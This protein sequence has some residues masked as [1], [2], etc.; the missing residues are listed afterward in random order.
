MDPVQVAT[1]ETM[2]T[3]ETIETIEAMEAMRV[4]PKFSKL[5]SKITPFSKWAE[6]FYYE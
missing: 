4:N 1:K 2:A 6:N 3:M 5:S